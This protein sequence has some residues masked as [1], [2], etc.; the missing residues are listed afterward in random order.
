MR[1][2]VIHIKDESKMEQL[3][4]ILHG[5]DYIEIESEVP[6]A[7]IKKWKP[8]SPFLQNPLEVKNFTFFSRDELYE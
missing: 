1:K 2:L 7:A 4:E 5:L 6:P 3:M 8:D